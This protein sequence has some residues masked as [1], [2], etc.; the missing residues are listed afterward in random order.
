LIIIKGPIFGLC[1]VERISIVD[2]GAS[3]AQKGVIALV[4]Y[5]GNL[6]DDDRNKI[7]SIASNDILK[8]IYS[9]Y[10]IDT[11][12]FGEYSKTISENITKL[13]SLELYK[14]YIKHFFINP[15]IIVTDRLDSN[16]L[17]WSY[18]TPDDGFN[19]TYAVGIWYPNGYDHS[20]VKLPA[21]N[22][23][24]SNVYV[25]KINSLNNIVLKY[26]DTTQNTPL[27]YLFWRPA[28]ALSFFLILCYYVIKN[29]IKLLPVMFPTIINILFWVMLLSHQSYRYLWFIQVNTYILYLIVLNNKKNS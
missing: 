10:N 25:P 19:S 3:F 20:A 15:Q 21:P 4:H 11:I 5:D 29:K 12:T 7:E 26:L 2:G 9:K 13:G 14:L 27:Y 6:S 16:N 28:I 24:D 23:L 1:G 17:L 22:D 18:V 8:E